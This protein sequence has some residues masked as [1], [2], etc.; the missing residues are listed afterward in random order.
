MSDIK[1][2]FFIFFLFKGRSQGRLI[3]RVREVWTPFNYVYF[4]PNDVVILVLNEEN[5]G[6]GE[7][8]R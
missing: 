4:H 8:A 5:C 3:I 1:A 7:D 6:C 2:S